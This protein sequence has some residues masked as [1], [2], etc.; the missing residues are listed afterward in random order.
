MY[1]LRIR[2]PTGNSPCVF[3]IFTQPFNSVK[4]F[5][6]FEEILSTPFG[7][8]VTPGLLDTVARVSGPLSRPAYS[9]DLRLTD[10]H[11]IFRR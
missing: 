7:C 5:A 3:I 9:C 2:L 8:N 1:S 11:C 10:Y 4:A 6:E